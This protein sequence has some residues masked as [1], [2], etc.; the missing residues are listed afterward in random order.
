MWPGSQPEMA[1]LPGGGMWVW[2]QRGSLLVVKLG[3]AKTNGFSRTTELMAAVDY[4]LRRA[5]Q[6]QMPV[7]VNLSF[8]NNYGGHDGRSLLETYLNEVSSYWKNVIVAGTGNEGAPG[9]IRQGDFLCKMRH[10]F[11]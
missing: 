1:G 2:R 3:V 8:G 10:L 9:F 6:Y 11:S 5:E 7:A 4:V